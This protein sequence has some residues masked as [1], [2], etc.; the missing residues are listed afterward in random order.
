VAAAA[1]V[2]AQETGR[3]EPHPALDLQ[4]RLDRAGFSPGE[5]DGTLGSNT[6][7]ALAAYTRAN[8]SAPGA[9][10]AATLVPY[11]VTPE[12]TAGPFLE[13]PEDIME[14]AALETLGYTS[15]IEALGERFHSAPG[16]LEALNPGVRLAAGATID[17]P[18]VAGAEE[19][20]TL[21]AAKVVVSRSASS[22]TAFDAEGTVIFHAPTTSGSE[23]D[24]LPLGDWLV[25]SVLRLPVF[26]YNPDLFWDADPTHSKA[27]IPPGPNGPVGVVWIDISR[28][29]YGMHGTPEPSQV[30]HSSSHGCVRL[31]NWDAERLAGLVKKGTP[32]VFIE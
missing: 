12:D 5:I 25:T 19:P 26:N 10:G 8:E 28:R 4:V 30:G 13:L 16:L 7:N 29:H 11:T 3:P 6:A 17:V 24:P 22:A 9:S 1:S 18:N 21:N 2:F 23:H 27:T 32:V 14:K 15:L 20:R 31:T